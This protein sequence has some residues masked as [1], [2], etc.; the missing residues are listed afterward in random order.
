MQIKKELLQLFWG[1]L[2]AAAG[3]GIFIRIHMLG[4]TLEEVAGDPS[5]AI[6]ARIC[7]YIMAVLLIG[8][9][10]RKIYHIVKTKN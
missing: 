7:L 4:S 2:L 5:R 1:V 10:I 9:G 3:V 8:G 6:F